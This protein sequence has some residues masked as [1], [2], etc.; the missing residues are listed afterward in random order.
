MF[1]AV[2]FA[3]RA[4][5]TG[6]DFT[7][8]AAEVG[9]FDVRIPPLPVAAPEPVVSFARERPAP[10]MRDPNAL[11]LI[12][13][14]GDMRPL[15][16][17]EAEAIRFALAHYRG[18]MSKMAKKL[19]IGRSTLYRKMKEYGFADAAPEEAATDQNG[20]LRQDLQRTDAAA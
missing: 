9:G 5:L 14:S 15:A 13:P 2:T 11:V 7:Q 12:D 18:R 4:D 6:M 17:L 1:R 19:G 8:I 10:D 20:D 3:E 16:E